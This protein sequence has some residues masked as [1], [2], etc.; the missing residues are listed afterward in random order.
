MARNTPKT[1]MVHTGSNN[2]GAIVTF[3]H[4]GTRYMVHGD[5]S[6]RRIEPKLNGKWMRK[7][8]QACRKEGI[9]LTPEVMDTI[10]A[11]VRERMA[12]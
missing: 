12:A 11:K 9:P 5:G 1:V 10:R 4:T 2:A 7:L 6:L 8:R 3:P